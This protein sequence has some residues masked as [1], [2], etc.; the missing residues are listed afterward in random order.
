MLVL[1]YYGILTKVDS[2]LSLTELLKNMNFIG[3]KIQ[4]LFED[5]IHCAACFMW[6]ATQ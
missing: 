6:Q 1:F 4:V 5:G 3:T 2:Y